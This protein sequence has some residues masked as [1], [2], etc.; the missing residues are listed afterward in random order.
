MANNINIGSKVT[1]SYNTE[2]PQIEKAPSWHAQPYG[3][4]IL[5]VLASLLAALIWFLFTRL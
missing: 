3:I 5:G 4:L 2:T 1:K